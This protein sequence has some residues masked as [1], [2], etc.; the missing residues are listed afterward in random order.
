MKTPSFEVEEGGRR[1]RPPSIL[2]FVESCL[3]IVALTTCLRTSITVEL[4][5]CSIQNPLHI[6]P[7]PTKI[8]RML[9]TK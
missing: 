3:S 1:Q 8:Y 4:H 5:F 2:W 7:Q 9:F 6:C